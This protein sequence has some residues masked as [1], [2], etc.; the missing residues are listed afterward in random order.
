[1]HLVND[2]ATP[3]MLRLTVPRS[4]RICEVAHPV[5]HIAR[6][7]APATSRWPAAMHR[8]DPPPSGRPGA[9]GRVT[10]VVDPHARILCLCARGRRFE[11]AGLPN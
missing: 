1:M 7:L 8:K 6:G 3:V 9:S 10:A 11:V 2:R 5:P 4:T